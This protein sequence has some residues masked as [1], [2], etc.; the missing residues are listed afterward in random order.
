MS[1]PLAIVSGG[2]LGGSPL[3]IAVD[4]WLSSS[5]TPPQPQPDHFIGGRTYDDRLV[6][7]PSSLA[8][9]ISA[10]IASL[11][12]MGSLPGRSLGISSAS[13]WLR[14]ALAPSAPAMASGTSQAQAGTRRLLRSAA[15]STSASHGHA[16]ALAWGDPD[17][18]V[19]LALLAA[20]HRRR[21]A[22]HRTR[23][24]VTP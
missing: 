4:G 6:S 3:S 16:V 17:E 15:G 13:A 1:R 18:A 22:A 8:V 23:P 11:H 14:R 10:A 12:G 20:Q 2:Y 24:Q 7:I 9:G 21:V 5:A 19:I